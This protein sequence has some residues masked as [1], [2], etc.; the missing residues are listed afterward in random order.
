MQADGSLFI[1][2]FLCTPTEVG[3]TIREVCCQIDGP[4]EVFLADAT[5]DFI[6]MGPRPDPFGFFDD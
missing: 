1:D 5:F 6:V 4:P 3:F 2:L